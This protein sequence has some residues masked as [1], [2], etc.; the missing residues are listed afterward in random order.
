[1]TWPLSGNCATL[2]AEMRKAGASLTAAGNQFQPASIIRP[3]PPM[4]SVPTA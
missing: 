4:T 2:G 1:M 3:M